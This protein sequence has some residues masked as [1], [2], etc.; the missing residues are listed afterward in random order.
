MKKVEF[1]FSSTRDL[2]GWLERKKWN[3]ESQEAFDK[4]LQ[5]F[6]DNGHEISVNGKEY[7]YWDCWELV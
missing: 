3:S 1:A 4:W 7:G 2:K 6:F 5:E